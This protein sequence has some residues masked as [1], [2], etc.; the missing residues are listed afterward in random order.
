M[1]NAVLSKSSSEDGA[2][3]L[4][5]RLDVVR[6]AYM[7]PAN[8]MCDG[9]GADEILINSLMDAYCA[10]RDFDTVAEIFDSLQTGLYHH[11]TC[12][13][14]EVTKAGAV[15]V[16]IAIKSAGEAGDAKRC[17]ELW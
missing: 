6:A 17:A 13:S 8:E 15:G 11:C 7:D 4:R 2:N 12:E 16:G 9:V 10:L 3:L 14:L 5:Y 1:K